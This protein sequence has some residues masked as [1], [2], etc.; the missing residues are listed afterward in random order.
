MSNEF[1][2]NLKRKNAQRKAERIREQRAVQ[3]K[4][5]YQA[6][7]KRNPGASVVIVPPGP[8]NE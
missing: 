6:W 8:A 7:R 1:D 5:D 2:P 4:K 3:Y